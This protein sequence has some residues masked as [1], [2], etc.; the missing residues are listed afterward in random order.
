M[1]PNSTG[2]NSQWWHAWHD[3]YGLGQTVEVAFTGYLTT[4]NWHPFS[5]TADQLDQAWSDFQTWWQASVAP[6]TTQSSGYR[7]PTR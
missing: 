1:P 3:A 6:P 7:R 4:K 5:L 2:S